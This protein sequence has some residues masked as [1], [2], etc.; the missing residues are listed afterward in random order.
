MII[1]GVGVV[2]FL[3]SIFVARHRVNLEAQHQKEVEE[4]AIEEKT[5]TQKELDENKEK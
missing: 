4:K 3:T 2:A 1:F 5:T